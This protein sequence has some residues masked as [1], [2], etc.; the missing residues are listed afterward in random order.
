MHDTIT[1]QLPP[2]D[3]ALLWKPGQLDGITVLKARFRRFSYK[4]HS[5][6]EFAIGVIEQGVQTFRHSGKQYTA[7]AGTMITVNPDEVHD[8][9]SASETGYQY[10]MVYVDRQ[11]IQAMLTGHDG[12]K[13]SPGYFKSPIV[14]DIQA[15]TA[16]RHALHFLD[17]DR[18][19]SL[20]AH[21][22]LAQALT[23][24]FQRHTHRRFSL[25]K[26]K[27]DQTMVR[28]ALDLIRARAAENI[29]LNE[30]ATAVGLSQYRFLRLFKDTTGLP[31]HAYQIQMRV[32][33]A[34]AAIEKGC[35]LAAAAF[36][37]GFSDQSHMSRC[38]KALYG[39]PP[40]QYKKAFFA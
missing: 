36:E 40:G 20:A 6:R 2:G 11:K 15:A 24:L 35:T 27:K 9:M 3:R 29:T 16:L 31:P 5:H 33:L 23:G 34:K 7:P 13:C 38:F 37:S 19:D 22:C 39:L 12:A 28:Q 18:S 4:K 17:E 25:K 1:Q 10:R 32:G 21:T 30:I 14:A 8:G 26:L